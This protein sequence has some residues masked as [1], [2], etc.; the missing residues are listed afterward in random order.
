[1]EPARECLEVEEAEEGRAAY[2]AEEEDE[3][4]AIARAQLST[5]L[6]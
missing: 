2:G 3:G 4:E 5:A 6:A 1:M